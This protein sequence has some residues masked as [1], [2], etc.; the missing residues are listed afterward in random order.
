MINQY[1]VPAYLLDELPGI[2]QELKTFSPTL[3]IYKTVQCLANY[4]KSKIVQH[5]LGTVKQCFAI[6]ENIY[7]KG[8]ELV[9][10]AVENVFVFSFSA[11]LNIGS[12][13]DKKELQAIMPVCLH[14]LYVQQ[15][16]RSGI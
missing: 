12:R 5:D 11:L 16:L 7:V 15:V 6:A 8:N 2:A 1:E 10:S 13:E 4:T 3:N 14:T 9:R